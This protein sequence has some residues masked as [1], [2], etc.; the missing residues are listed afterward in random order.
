[1]NS[2]VIEHSVRAITS[3]ATGLNYRL[4]RS[5]LKCSGKLRERSM[6]TRSI[7]TLVAIALIA[8]A[9]LLAAVNA[10]DAGS[11]GKS[12]KSDLQRPAH[13]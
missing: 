6:T 7:N 9:T 13:R 2:T 8:A 11:A 5:S 3:T 1:M 12:E 4:R 10:A